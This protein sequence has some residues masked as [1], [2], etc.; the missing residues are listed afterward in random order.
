MLRRQGHRRALFRIESL[1]DFVHRPS[2]G[3]VPA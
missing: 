2:S 1:Q 3:F